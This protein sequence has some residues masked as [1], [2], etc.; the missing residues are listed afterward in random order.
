[1]LQLLLLLLL[2]LLRV[3]C[4]CLVLAAAAAGSRPSICCNPFSRCSFQHCIL[5]STAAGWVQAQQLHIQFAH[6][7]QLDADCNSGSKTDHRL[8]K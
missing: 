2:L 7:L 6:N 4:C 5:I 8:F 3:C 1:L